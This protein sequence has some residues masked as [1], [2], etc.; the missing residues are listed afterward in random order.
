MTLQQCKYILEIVNKGSFN[1][2]AKSLFVAQTSISSAVKSIE[3][4]LNIKIFERS[5]K[6]VY[7]TNDGAEFV[8]YAK[9][10]V[11]QADYITE[12]Y[13]AANEIKRISVSTQ[14]YDFAAEIFGSF[15]NEITEEDFDFSLREVETF[16]VIND[17]EMSFSDIGILAIKDSDMDLMERFLS[18][19]QIGFHMLFRTPFHVYIRKTHPLS[20]KEEITFADLANYPY[21]T[22]EQGDYGASMFTEEFSAKISCDKNVRITDRATLMNLLLITDCYTIGTG[23]MNHSILAGGNLLSI[24]LLSSGEY[25]IGYIM[26]NDKK[27]TEYTRKFIDALSVLDNKFNS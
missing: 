17:V 4:E 9:Q 1:E 22:Y 2:A 26:R 11:E 27:I 10:L 25:V 7:L 20:H 8:R 23:T 16:N 3:T 21:I 5:N 15:L 6:G 19:K 18:K 24:P 12:R 13:S 14:H